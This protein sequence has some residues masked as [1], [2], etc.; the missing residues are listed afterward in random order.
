[1]LHTGKHGDYHRPS[2]DAERINTDGLAQIS[3]LMFNV[4]VELAEAPTLPGFRSAARGESQ[5]MQRSRERAVAGPPGR[6]GVR[7]DPEVA[8]KSGQIVIVA[9]TPRSAADLAGLKPGDKIVRFAGRKVDGED[10]FRRTVLA[11]ANP[12]EVTL[13]R[14]GEEKPIDLTVTLTGE[15]VRLGIG[16]RIDDAE[17]N[18]IIVNRVTP[19]SA[20]DQA[21][22][23]V[24]DRIYRVGGRDFADG[25]EFRWLAVNA[26]GILP[27]EVETAGKVRTVKLK[28]VGLGA[29]AVSDDDGAAESK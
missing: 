2:D 9:V 29:T 7:W 3:R 19:G 23:R 22:V 12:V 10:L 17:P 25:E 20:A 1:M 6:L 24:G 18:T 14:A 28:L 8:Q 13:E 5:S 21:G 16:W 4:L 11:A 27:L 26:A 15:P